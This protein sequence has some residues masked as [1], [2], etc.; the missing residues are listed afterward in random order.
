VTHDQNVLN[1]LEG[2]EL[3]E[4]FRGIFKGKE[5]PFTYDLK[6]VR[7][8]ANGENTDE[9]TDFYR[10]ANNAKHSEMYTCWIP[11]GDY[12]IEEGTL[13]VCHGSHM[14]IDPDLELD[15]VDGKIELPDGFDESFEKVW[16]SSDFRQGDVCIFDI[17]AVHA[18]VEN[19]SFR[20]RVSIDTR[21]QSES[22]A[23]RNP[24]FKRISSAKN[25]S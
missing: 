18:S 17:R 15:Q 8:M 12:R 10:F 4:I 25:I 14:L 21:W 7:I 11:L 16:Y 6:W 9:H 13:A 19:Q 3:E 20:Y 24:G 23:C 5:D 22:K 1:V 2:E